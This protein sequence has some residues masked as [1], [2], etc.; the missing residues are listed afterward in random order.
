[1]KQFIISM[2]RVDVT[3]PHLVPFFV[4]FCFVLNYHNDNNSSNNEAFISYL[5]IGYMNL[6]SPLS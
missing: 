1:M 2:D 6:F 5:L 3:W 4:L